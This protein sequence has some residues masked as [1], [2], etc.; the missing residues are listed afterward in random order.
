MSGYLDQ[1]FTLLPIIFC[2][3]YRQFKKYHIAHARVKIYLK[4]GATRGEVHISEGV[5]EGV[6][7]LY[8]NNLF[9]VFLQKFI[10]WLKINLFHKDGPHI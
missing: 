7:F 4:Q 6:I 3:E 10:I 1:N 9:H 5:Q 2:Y 8:T